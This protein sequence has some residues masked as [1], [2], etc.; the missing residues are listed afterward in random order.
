[1]LF[2]IFISGHRATESNSTAEMIAS[3]V[4]GESFKDACISFSKTTEAKGLGDFCEERLSF[5]GCRL[6]DNIGDAKKGF[7]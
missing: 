1:M 3:G 5:W 2:N 4:E 6:Y 7:G